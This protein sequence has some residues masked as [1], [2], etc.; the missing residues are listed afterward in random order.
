MSNSIKEL[1]KAI[2][3]LYELSIAEQS[4]IVVD[5][6]VINE[7]IKAYGKEL[8]TVVCM[9]EL[10]ELTKELSK[11]LRG[12]HN[13]ENLLTEVADV[14]ICLHMIKEMYRIDTK[15]LNE[16]IERKQERQKARLNNENK[17]SV[18]KFN[19]L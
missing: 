10:A 8:Q 18:G 12:I 1:K 6:N 7:S 4:E 3:N 15:L 14:I 16:E 9:E 2:D 5:K 19:E 13:K 17:R 11:Y